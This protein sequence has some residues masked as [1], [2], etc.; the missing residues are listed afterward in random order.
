MSLDSVPLPYLVYFLHWS[1]KIMLLVSYLAYY[2]FYWH[3]STIFVFYPEYLL[4]H[5]AWAY[6]GTK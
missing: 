2:L 6:G 1:L 5:K 4:R 3:V